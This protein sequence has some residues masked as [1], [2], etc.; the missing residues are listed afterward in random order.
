[1]PYWTITIKVNFIR[2]RLVSWK[3]LKPIAVGFFAVD[4]FFRGVLFLQKNSMEN[5]IN[6][7]K[8]L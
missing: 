1:M 3:I 5:S 7:V 2:Q 4:T 6:I 8:Y